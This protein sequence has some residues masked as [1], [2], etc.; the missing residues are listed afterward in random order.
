M[1]EA[2][3]ETAADLR[4]RLD[5]WQQADGW[6]IANL[7]PLADGGI[8][9]KATAGAAV[10]PTT[11]TSSATY[12]R[13]FE[14]GI[15]SPYIDPISNI[16]TR[17]LIAVDAQWLGTQAAVSYSA[18]APYLNP[19]FDTTKPKFVRTWR[20]DIYKIVYVAVT[21][22]LGAGGKAWQLAPAASGTVNAPDGT[23]FVT[24]PFQDATGKSIPFHPD[25]YV[26]TSFLFGPQPQGMVQTNNEYL[27]FVSGFDAKGNPATNIGWGYDSG[28]PGFSVGSNNNIFQLAGYL[29]TP[30]WSI[31][32][33]DAG[34]VIFGGVS[35]TQPAIQFT[36]VTYAAA[37]TL[38]F[39]TGTPI[40]LGSTPTTAPELVGRAEVPVG[41]S[42]QFQAAVDPAGAFTTFKDGQLTSDI[43]LATQ[44]KYDLQ[45]TLT[46][47]AAGDRTPIVRTLGARVV[48]RTDLGDVAEVVAWNELIDPIYH[49]S[50]VEEISIRG[51]HDGDRDYRDAISQLLANNAPGKFSFRVY[52]G[53]R[54]L[55]RDQW[56]HIDDYFPDD[57]ILE[58]AYA[59]LPCVSVLSLLRQA[60]P[61]LS[62][63]VVALPTADSSNPGGWTASSGT[64]LFQQIADA[65]I[66]AAGGLPDD[67][68]Y[69]Q[70]PSNPA[71]AD[72]IATLGGIATPAQTVGA[73]LQFRAA[74]AAAA[75]SL[76]CTVFLREGTTVRATLAVT[77][78]VQDTGQGSYTPFQYTLTPTEQAA[79]GNWSN[80]NLLIRA[81]GTGQIRVGWARLVVLG[82]RAPLQFNP[83]TSIQTAADNL[84]QNQ[85][86]LDARYQGPK[87]LDAAPTITVSKT[88]AQSAVGTTDLTRAKTELDALAWIAGGSYIS[89]QGAL[90]FVPLFQVTTGTDLLS[91]NRTAT[92]APL[93]GPVRAVFPIEETVP[94]AVTAGWR[95]RIPLFAVPWGWDGTR[96]AGEAQVVNQPALSFFSQALIDPETRCPEGI[97]Q[98]LESDG[99]ARALSIRHAQAF[100]L[101]MMVW[102]FRTT[103]P[104]PEL[105]RGDV[106]LVQT[107]RFLGFDPIANRALSGRLWVRA[108][109]VGR[110]DA[111]GRE[112]AAWVQSYAA[113]TPIP[114]AIAVPTINPQNPLALGVTGYIGEQAGTAAGDNL[115]VFWSGSSAVQAVKIATSTVS[116]PAAGTGTLYTG[117]QGSQTVTGPFAFGTVIFITIT[118]YATLDGSGASGVPAQVLKLIDGSSISTP[119]NNQGS[120][121]PT[122]GDGTIFSYTAGGTTTG[123]MFAVISTSADYTLRFAD[124][125][126]ITAKATNAYDRPAA[127]TLSQ[128]AGGALGARN[129]WVRV[130]FVKKNP[131]NNSS[132]MYRSSAETAN[133]AVSANNLLK[134]TSPAAVA[135]YD[136]WVVL[137]GTGA[138]AEVIE[139]R[140][141]GGG[142]VN[143][144]PI[145]FG[146]DYTEPTAGAVTSSTLR[147]PYDPSMDSGFT[148]SERAASPT[149]YKGY[150]YFDRTVGTLGGVFRMAAGVSAAGRRRP[151]TSRPRN[152]TAIR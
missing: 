135:G 129:Y 32:P 106:V 28:H 10:G 84:V 24:I 104:R 66:D 100:G 52:V 2:R 37:T 27:I 41:T 97:S 141:G 47:S 94:I 86:A 133:F 102:R 19:R 107:D 79:I 146:T 119:Y 96:Y 123:H 81:N 18:V 38:T 26:T 25:P 14:T 49:K 53:D 118:P 99:M 71:N 76:S 142:A 51:I 13:A 34:T 6:P 63:D 112:W 17:Q 150:L 20:V 43:G 120:I 7:E 136:G 126:A 138:N 143:D 130:A 147:T 77:V 29:I 36:P 78:N 16:N 82:L 83:G 56:L 131:Q 87:Y 117:R 39:K 144:G 93:A 69:I 121:V 114:T 57:E 4:Q 64:Q 74:T 5:Q 11:V 33:G 111:M 75:Q 152:R 139:Q 67:T 108:V 58:D 137:I 31:Y 9:L 89:S 12:Y 68:T 95:Q 101:G 60:L 72:Y 15:V 22:G 45:V 23:G 124:G 127:P 48:A 115:A 110:Y 90:K 8:R 151:M 85:V 91:G 59:E 21:S 46:P 134:V 1:V 3:V 140:L 92:Y 55:T 70:S 105:E 50:E 113:I 61:K 145:A 103:Y 73:T 44:Q 122:P 148:I 125:S 88:I 98:Y 35:S 30:N 65:T 149:I 62:S 80:L 116:Q 54:A 132:V 109:I 40:N 128:V 42:V